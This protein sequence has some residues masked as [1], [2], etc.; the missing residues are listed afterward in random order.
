M[1]RHDFASNSLWPDLLDAAA[2]AGHPDD[3]HAAALLDDQRAEEITAQEAVAGCLDPADTPSDQDD[4]GRTV[5]F[6]PPNYDPLQRARAAVADVP[7][8]ETEAASR[9]LA[10][11]GH[12]DEMTADDIV[13]DSR[14][15]SE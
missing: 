4:Q 9:A 5:D 2:L 10:D 15:W 11:T 8:T 1:N 7:S 13:D 12:V 6:C 14:G 3:D